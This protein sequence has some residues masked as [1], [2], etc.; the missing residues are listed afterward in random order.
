MAVSSSNRNP[1]H[2]GSLKAWTA[3]KIPAIVISASG[4]ATGGRVLHHLK[5]A[6]PD[7]RNAVVFAGY[8]AEGTRGRSLLEKA[9]TIKM[10]GEEVPVKCKVEFI[11]SMSGH[12]DRS[13]LFQWMEGLKDKPNMVFKVHGEAPGIETY[14]QAIRDRFGWKVFVPHYME[15]FSLFEGI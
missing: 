2:R 5:A 1:L 3:S 12:A 8:Q 14:A 15:S 7:P 9:P 11:S 13:E 6:L 10:F 4:M